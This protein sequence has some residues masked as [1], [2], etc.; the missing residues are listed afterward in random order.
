[1]SRGLITIRRTCGEA[2]AVTVI[3]YFFKILKKIWHMLS[4]LKHH[5]GYMGTLLLC[6]STTLL[7]IFDHLFKQTQVSIEVEEL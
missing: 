7:K 4:I 2:S 3:F 5:G 1:M 6:S